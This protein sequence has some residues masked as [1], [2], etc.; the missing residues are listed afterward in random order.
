MYTRV[1]RRTLIS[2]RADYEIHDRLNSK[3]GAY[4][5]FLEFFANRRNDFSSLFNIGL[6][7]SRDRVS[8][9]IRDG[10][11]D[12]LRDRTFRQI[13]HRSLFGLFVKFSTLSPSDFA[14]QLRKGILNEEEEGNII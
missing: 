9:K 11:P 10:P 8:R 1:A 14:F 13:R 4:V 12:H 7:L 5:A 6:W 2:S 3:S